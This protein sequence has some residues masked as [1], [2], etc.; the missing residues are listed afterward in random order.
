MGQQEYSTQQER[1][2][3][4]RRMKEGKKVADKTRFSE[5]NNGK[6]QKQIKQ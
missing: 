3:R 2:R 6:T 4:Q 1:K 5:R